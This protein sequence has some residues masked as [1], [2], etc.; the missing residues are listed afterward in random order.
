MS[1]VGAGLFWFL[2][3][4]WRADEVG[5]SVEEV[6][7]AQRRGQVRS[8]HQVWRHHWDQR[9]VG[10]VKITVEDGEGHEEREGPKQRR[11]EAAE[12]LHPHREDVTRQTVRLQTPERQREK[13][14]YSKEQEV[15]QTSTILR[16][17][18]LKLP[19]DVRTSE[20]DQ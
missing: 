11:E 5:D 1:A 6:D 8:S 12:T 3:S 18:Q 14:L 19:S 16:T 7:H 4:D 13:P 20:T 10:A 17:T 9:H 15:K 2:T